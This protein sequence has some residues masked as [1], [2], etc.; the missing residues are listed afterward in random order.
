MR[1]YYVPALLYLAFIGF[2]LW[3]HG[4]T[5]AVPAALFLYLAGSTWCVVAALRARAPAKLDMAVVFAPAIPPLVG[6]ANSI[7][8]SRAQD[9]AVLGALVLIPV[10]GVAVLVGLA[11]AAVIAARRRAVRNT[12][13][14]RQ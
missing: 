10:A 14:L 6:A 2:V 12:A 9:V 4:W 3:G 5:F 13:G 8:A 7:E 1:R 11:A